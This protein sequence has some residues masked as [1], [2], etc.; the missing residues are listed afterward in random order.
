MLP[1]SPSAWLPAPDGL[2]GALLCLLEVP[3]ESDDVIGD[4]ISFY[5]QELKVSSSRQRIEMTINLN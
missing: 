5:I 3:S 1:F 2:K 4:L